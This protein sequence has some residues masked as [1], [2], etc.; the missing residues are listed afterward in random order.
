[1]MVVTLVMAYVDNVGYSLHHGYGIQYSVFLVAP[2]LLANYVPLNV[3]RCLV[4]LKQTGSMVL[5]VMC[6]TM[7]IALVW[8]LP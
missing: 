5:V 7:I 2:S 6:Y 1:M 4:S 3:E 8:I